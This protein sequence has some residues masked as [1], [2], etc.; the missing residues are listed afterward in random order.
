[1]V[2][3]VVV[4]VVGVV[5]V[6]VVGVVVVVVVGW[7]TGIAGRACGYVV[8]VDVVVVVSSTAEVGRTVSES[9]GMAASMTTAAN[10]RPAKPV[11]RRRWCVRVGMTANMR[12]CPDRTGGPP[13]SRS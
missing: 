3:V 2:G 11:M 9:T 4:V 13:T 12:R 10:A 7:G 1:M 5:V 8:L 6:V